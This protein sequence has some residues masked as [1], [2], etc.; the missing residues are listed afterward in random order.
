MCQERRDRGI[1]IGR[2]GRETAA[3]L[4]VPAGVWRHRMMIAARQNL[5]DDEA[6]GCYSAPSP[7]SA[8]ETVTGIATANLRRINVGVEAFPGPTI[9]G[10]SVRFSNQIGREEGSLISEHG[11]VDAYLVI[12]RN[13]LPPGEQCISI[14]GEQNRFPA[15]PQE[16]ATLPTISV[17]V[18]TVMAFI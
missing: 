15:R 2:K 10:D 16:Q 12:I 14:L 5:H 3:R 11:A 7:T 4:L 8:Q 18:A 1:L 17:L 9:P 13:E 6:L